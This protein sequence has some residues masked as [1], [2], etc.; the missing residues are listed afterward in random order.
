MRGTDGHFVITRGMH[1]IEQTSDGS[2][3]IQSRLI[4]KNFMKTQITKTSNTQRTTISTVR[5]W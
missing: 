3:P 4:C 1:D 2:S 5:G